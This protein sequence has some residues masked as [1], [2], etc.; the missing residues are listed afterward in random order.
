M[1]YVI[2]IDLGINGV[3]AI[4]V[5]RGGIVHQS[6]SLSYPLLQEK[7]DQCEQDPEQWY[8]MTKKVI[9]KLVKNFDRDAKEIV[10]ISF[11]GTMH[12]MVLLDKNLDV[13]R[14]MILSSDTRT[15]QQCQEIYDR[16]SEDNLGES[17]KNVALE[18]FTLPQLLWVKEHEPQI[19]EK[20]YRFLLPKDYLR[21]RITGNIHTEYS[22]AAG[23]LLLDIENKKWN[24]KIYEAFGIRKDIYPPLVESHTFCGTVTT[25][26]AKKTGLSPSTKVFA[27]G[28]DHACSAI[29]AGILSKGKTLCRIG[30]SGVML[31]YEEQTN[32]D[33]KGKV[34][35]FN[36]GKENAYYSMGVTH[37]AGHSLKWIQQV[38][39]KDESI[40]S[41]LEG[42]EHIPPGANGLLFTPYL[43][44]ERLS[45]ADEIIRASF[46]GMNTTH[47][48]KHFVRAVLEGITFS[49]KESLDI[50]RDNHPDK[51]PIISIGD[52]AKSDVWLQMQA[53]IFD[54]NV[55]KLAHEQ[56]PALGA[57]ILAAYGCGWYDSLQECSRVFIAYEKSYKPNP[58]RV[59]KYAILYDL[60]NKVHG[61]TVGINEE[62]VEFCDG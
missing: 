19:F 34:H 60:Y 37:S 52:G 23:T 45:H 57:A 44:G 58:D 55:V 46:I 18:G 32:K 20:I 39:A 6:L 48:K 12:G 13:L 54:T 9:T 42:L 14:N 31:S 61:Q 2:G 7:T 5:D 3:K 40:L 43:Q 27:G 10:G 28:A 26:F 50:L 62:L 15:T 17:T 1:S 4:L 47:T 8:R 30:T 41:L 16:M 24:D 36:H 38:F 35:Y 11:S 25:E 22:D 51:T 56:G 29:G 59:Q 49:L 21:F 33:N 53:D